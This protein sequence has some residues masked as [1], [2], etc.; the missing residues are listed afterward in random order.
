MKERT[1]R[2]FIRFIKHRVETGPRGGWYFI[3][4][5]GRKIYLSTLSNVIAWAWEDSDTSSDSHSDTSSDTHSEDDQ[6]QL[7]LARF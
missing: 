1:G 5:S 2:R 7:T 4:N 6:I 3:S